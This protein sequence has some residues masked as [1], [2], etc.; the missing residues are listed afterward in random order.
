MAH[1]ERGYEVEPHCGTDSEGAPC[2]ERGDEPMLLG[3]TGGKGTLSCQRCVEG[4]PCYG[5]GGAKIKDPSGTT[6]TNFPKH[7][8]IT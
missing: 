8:L 6:L 2:Y 1:V 4:A 3:E 5:R 7:W